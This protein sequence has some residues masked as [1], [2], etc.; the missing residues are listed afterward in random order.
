MAGR[1]PAFPREPDHACGSRT[2]IATVVELVSV[3]GVQL[4][5][6]LHGPSPAHAPTLVF[7]HEGLGSISQWRDFPAALCS[8][9]ECG[10]LV[11]N[12]RGHGKS[13]PLMGPRSLGFMHD[14]ALAVLPRLLDIFEIT[15]PIL[16]GHS[17]GASIALIYAGSGI[18]R[19][20][21]LALEAPHVFVEDVTVS[22]IAE[23]RELYQTTDLR[24]KF[25]RHHG[26][27]ADTLFRHWTDVW[28]RP[29]FRSWNIED[30]LRDIDAPVL[31]IQGRNDEYGTERQV[32]TMVSA[33]GGRCDAIM[34][35]NCRHFPHIDQRAIVE[36][37]MARF[38]QGLGIRD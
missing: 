15:R 9:T 7:L 36:D 31:V 29:E 18:G 14:E 1:V 26:P 32:D 8:R 6:A 33:L 13:D 3:D 16:V 11:Y 4:E 24:T 19:P 20:I 38:V 22:R 25:T 2:T 34:L 27:N 10:G 23:L 12:R 28:L 17:D 30:Y 5:Y 35:D 37:A 21:A